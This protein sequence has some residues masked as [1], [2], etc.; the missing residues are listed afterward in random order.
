MRTFQLVV[1]LLRRAVLHLFF[2]QGG[3]TRSMSRSK[4]LILFSLV[5]LMAVPIGQVFAQTPV[6]ISAQTTAQGEVTAM[7]SDGA[8]MGSRVT[9][10]ISGASPASEGSAYEGWLVSDDGDPLSIG[11]ITVTRSG[12]MRTLQLVVV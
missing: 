9:V 5:L 3:K 10:T 7:I 11:I 12:P 8:A 2:S 4:F 1:V 6:A